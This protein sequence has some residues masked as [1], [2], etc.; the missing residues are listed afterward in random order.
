LPELPPRP[1]MPPDYIRP[2]LENQTF[3]PHH[4]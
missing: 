4:Y 1:A 3:V 2:P